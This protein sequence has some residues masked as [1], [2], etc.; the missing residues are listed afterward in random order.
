MAV[1]GGIPVLNPGGQGLIALSSD[2]G[3]TWQVVD[4]SSYFDYFDVFFLDSLTGFVGGG[5]D[6]FPYDP[7]LLKTSDGGLSWQ[8]VS[9]PQ[10]AH[11]IRALY[12]ANKKKGW[13]VGE[14]GSLIRTEDGGESWDTVNLG[15]SVTLYDVEFS[16]TLR[17][18]VVGDSGV[19]FVTVDGGSSWS[20]KSPVGVKESY[21]YQGA[22]FE[23]PIFVK[24][25][26]TFSNP[27]EK[28]LLYDL[29]DPT[30]RVLRMGQLEPGLNR[31]PTGRMGIMFLR[32]KSLGK[33]FK[34][35][36]VVIS[37]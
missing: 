30:G 17:G 26:I 36:N 34:I 14:M 35:L 20:L 18:G 23:V 28:P 8:S 3:L 10:G 2:W 13:A 4:T 31:I 19:V 1:V 24:G 6:T 22:R 32:V 5:T 25:Y 27:F 11:T 7:V 16:D 21:E 33:V 9:L 37:K 15:V 12:F 29:I